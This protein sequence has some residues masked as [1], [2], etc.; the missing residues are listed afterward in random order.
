MERGGD[1]GVVYFES[2]DDAHKKKL[3]HS[4]TDGICTCVFVFFVN[5]FLF[6]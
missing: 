2:V 3:T 5:E 4:H 6:A 1:E